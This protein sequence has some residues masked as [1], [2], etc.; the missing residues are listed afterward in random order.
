MESVKQLCTKIEISD[1]LKKLAQEEEGVSLN[2]IL[3]QLRSTKLED[4]KA[5]VLKEELAAYHK[6]F[7][8]NLKAEF[9]NLTKTEVELATFFFF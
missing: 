5:L 8:N 2:N 6:D 1:N 4:Q 7:L 9:P 3:M